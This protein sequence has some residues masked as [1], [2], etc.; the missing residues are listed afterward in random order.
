MPENIDKG[1]FI[2]PTIFANVKNNMTIAKEEIFGP[3]LSI[4]G[5]K[6]ENEAVEIANDSEYGLSGYIS[7]S[8]MEK[9]ISIAKKIR[10]GM[11]HI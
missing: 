9:A 1:F 10:T 3:V 5:Y 7:S 6:N 11:I 2:K 8:N 4:I